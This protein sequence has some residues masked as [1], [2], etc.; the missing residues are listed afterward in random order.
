MTL[1]AY[2]E[3]KIAELEARV[4]KETAR[5]LANGDPDAIHDLRVSIRRLTQALRAFADVIGRRRA[6]RT[7]RK[8]RVWMDAAAEIRNRDIAL[9]LL[10]AAGVPPDSALSRQTADSRAAAQKRLAELLAGG[11]E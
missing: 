3:S 10:A 4:K 9:E 2:A 6:R 7:R 5:T 1:R 11:A 8:L